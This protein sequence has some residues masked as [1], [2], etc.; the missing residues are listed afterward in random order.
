MD[1]MVQL[2]LIQQSTGW[3]TG[4]C[5]GGGYCL[6]TTARAA[7]QQTRKS[8]GSAAC[9]LARCDGVRISSCSTEEFNRSGDTG[10]CRCH[11]QEHTLQLLAN[12]HCL[13]AHAG[14]VAEQLQEFISFRHAAL[15]DKS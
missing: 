6:A 1:N 12:W 4:C 8:A 10:G 14:R 7:V 2:P 15:I 13:A 11:A 9:P 3:R 5:Q